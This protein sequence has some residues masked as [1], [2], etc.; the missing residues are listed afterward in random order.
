MNKQLISYY[1][2]GK[3]GLYRA[4]GDHWR[5]R[6]TALAGPAGSLGELIASYVRSNVEHGDFGRLLVWDGLTGAAS[7]PRFAEGV[8]A[9]VEDLRGRQR[10]GEFPADLD[11]AA[12]AVA[13]FA[14]AAAG[15]TFPHVVAAVSDLTPEEFGE[16][17]ATQMC[18]LVDR[19]SG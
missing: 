17:Y 18:A 2:G 11:P 6:E 3:E 8:R 9:I 12:L 19:L 7:D 5:E 15:V 14:I 16:H 4:V 13:L 1:F 10:A